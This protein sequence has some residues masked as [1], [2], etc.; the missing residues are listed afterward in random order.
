[1]SDVTLQYP[2]GELPLAEVP[3]T[4]GNSG[5]D[6]SQF[7]KATDR[8]AKTIVFCQNVDHAARMREALVNANADLAA[9]DLF[10][11]GHHAQECGFAAA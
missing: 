2:G 1:M 6:V 9:A 8:F 7:L 4:V 10:K 3:A 11:P 5:L